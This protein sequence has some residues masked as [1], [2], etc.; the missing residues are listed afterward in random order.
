MACGKGGLRSAILSIFC[1][2]TAKCRGITSP[3]LWWQLKRV[4]SLFCPHPGRLIRTECALYSSISACRWRWLWFLSRLSL[5]LNGSKF[6]R[7]INS[8]NN[9][10]TSKQGS[11]PRFYS[12]FLEPFLQASRLPRRLSFSPLFSAGICIGRIYW[13]GRSSHYIVCSVGRRLFPIR[14]SN[15]CLWCWWVCFWQDILQYIYYQKMWALWIRSK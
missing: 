15:K 3:S 11:W 6:L 2:P 14:K 12:S 13:R 1:S 5:C 10:S 7:R 9:G 4:P 8:S